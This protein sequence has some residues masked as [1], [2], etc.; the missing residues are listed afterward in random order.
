MDPLKFLQQKFGKEYILGYPFPKPYCKDKSDVKSHFTRLA[1]PSNKHS[2]T[3]PF[4]FAIVAVKNFYNF[5][6]DL[7]KRLNAVGLSFR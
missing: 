3:L 4:V 2:N 7:A 1:I 5:I 6:K